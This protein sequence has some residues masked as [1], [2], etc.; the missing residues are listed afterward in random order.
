MVQNCGGHCGK[1]NFVVTKHEKYLSASDYISIKRAKS[2]NC[3]MPNI[4]MN[5]KCST[6]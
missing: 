5:S 1:K 6:A 2:E 3:E 4:T